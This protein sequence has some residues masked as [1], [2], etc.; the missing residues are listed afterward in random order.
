MP[1][2]WFLNEIESPRDR[3]LDLPFSFHYKCIMSPKKHLSLARGEK[4]HIDVRATFAAVFVL[5]YWLRGYR[6]SAV[7]NRFELRCQLK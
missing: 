2:A 6:L 5:I 7:A 3:T 1:S 4:F